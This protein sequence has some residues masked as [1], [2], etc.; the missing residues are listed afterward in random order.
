MTMSRLHLMACLALALTASSVAAADDKELAKFDGTWVG[1]S[2]IMDGTPLEPEVCRQYV[3]VVK[4]GK[5]VTTYKGK[6]V[7]T[8]ATYQLINPGKTPSQIDAIIESGPLKGQ[9]LKGI[10]KFEGERL[11]TCFADSGKDRPTTFESKK[12]SGNGLQVSQKVK[13]NK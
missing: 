10:Y 13:G 8:T 6:E 1:V 5:V 12:G 3:D 7:A 4:G 9:T 11:V 2:G